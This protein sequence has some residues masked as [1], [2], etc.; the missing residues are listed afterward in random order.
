VTEKYCFIDRHIYA[1]NKCGVHSPK[2][3][4]QNWIPRTRSSTRNKSE[5]RYPSIYAVVLFQGSCINRII[6]DGGRKYVFDWCR[7][8][9]P[10]SYF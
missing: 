5:G 6:L 7:S 2:H 4:T 1:C 9:I 10:R 3:G 8:Q